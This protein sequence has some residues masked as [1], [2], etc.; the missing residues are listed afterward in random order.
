MRVDSPEQT[1]ELA[2]ALAAFFR[3]QPGIEEIRANRDC[4][5]VVLAYDPDLVTADDLQVLSRE[6]ANGSAGWVVQTAADATSALAGVADR[7][8]ESAQILVHEVR[9]LSSYASSWLPDFVKRVT[10]LR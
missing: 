5:S 6:A 8:L 9:R 1:D 10:P 3:D 7:A 4:H 2:R